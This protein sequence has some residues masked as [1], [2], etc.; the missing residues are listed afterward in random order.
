MLA[1]ESSASGEVHEAGYGAMTSPNRLVVRSPYNAAQT[2]SEDVAGVPM[3]VVKVGTYFTTPQG[4]RIVDL[5]VAC[6]TGES[7]V[8]GGTC[9][10]PHLDCGKH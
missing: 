3:E 7:P 9:Y 2:Y 6:P 8:S 1:T 4:L 5:M 10:Y